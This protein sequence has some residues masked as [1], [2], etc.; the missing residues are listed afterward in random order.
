MGVTVTNLL[1]G[2]ATLY[3]AP[4]GSPEPATANT[5]FSTAWTDLGGTSDGAKSTVELEYTKKMVDQIVDAAGATL[6]SRNAK[7]GTTLAEATLE[8]WARSLNELTTSSITDG[9]FTPSNGVPG[10]PNYSAIALKGLGPSGKPRLVI[11]RRA[12]QVANVE[13]AHKKD[14]MQL[15]P[16]QWKAYY[17]SA[18]I[19]P[20]VVID[21]Q[22]A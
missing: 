16:V 6:T 9:K 20:F 19:A 22:A 2:P 11:V 1:Q 21:K 18:S 3:H 15:L 7:I 12:L 8:N 14:G 4:F 17:V 10:E 13:S 5:A